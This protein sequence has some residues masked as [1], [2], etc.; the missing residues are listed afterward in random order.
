MSTCPDC[1]ESLDPEAAF[2]PHCGYRVRDGE[3]APATKACPDCAESIPAEA[4]ECPVCA[5]RQPSAASGVEQ[6]DDPHLERG[7]RPRDRR[8][9]W[10]AGVVAG[11]VGLGL[12]GLVSIIGPSKS[13]KQD[14]RM[15]LERELR[16]E[17]ETTVTETTTS[18]TTTTTTTTSEDK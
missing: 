6:L 9:M 8:M 5:C 2:C 17:R 14:E 16:E 11:L 3:S 10:V 7:L 1:A 12:G 18:T 4:T 15:S 13:A